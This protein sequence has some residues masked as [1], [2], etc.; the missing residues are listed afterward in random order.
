M[1]FLGDAD[2]DGFVFFRIE[3]ANHRRRGGQRN[4]VLAGAPAKE[5]ADSQSFLVRGHVPYFS[6]KSL[7]PE[8]LSHGV[9]PGRR[10]GDE[11]K[12]GPP[13]PGDPR[14]PPEFKRISC[15]LRKR[16][17]YR[18]FLPR[19]ERTS[20]TPSNAVRLCSSMMGL[21]STI[22]METMAS[23]SAIISIARCASR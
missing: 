2:G 5:D 16:M 14:A 8:G 9:F 6:R 3:P 19:P 7:K 4:F 1:A 12:H 13:L 20:S 21:I 22:S 15:A 17:L 18:I 10:L 23:L 11:A